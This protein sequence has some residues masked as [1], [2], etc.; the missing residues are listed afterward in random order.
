M[1][2]NLII[3]LRYRK[4]TDS[5]LFNTLVLNKSMEEKYIGLR[6]SLTEAIDAVILGNT[7][8]ISHPDDSPISKTLGYVYAK[9]NKHLRVGCKTKSAYNPFDWFSGNSPKNLPYRTVE[10]IL[11][12]TSKTIIEPRGLSM[13]NFRNAVVLNDKFGVAYTGFVYGVYKEELEI[14]NKW[15]RY[16]KISDSELTLHKIEDIDRVALLHFDDP[17]APKGNFIRDVQASARRGRID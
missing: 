6:Q 9:T 14:G 2:L 8:L 15:Y 16:G 10:K 3:G 1:Y 7:I 13:R 17:T 12:A 5:K 4:F 11:A